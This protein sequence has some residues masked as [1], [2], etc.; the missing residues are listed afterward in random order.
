MSC[1]AWLERFHYNLAYRRLDVLDD[2]LVSWEIQFR[3]GV[4]SVAF[5]H[6]AVDVH[7]NGAGLY[8]V[9][10]LTNKRTWK[11]GKR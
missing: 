6:P 11:W 4:L 3:H 1:K 9:L 2:Q 7:I 10:I 5:R 8:R